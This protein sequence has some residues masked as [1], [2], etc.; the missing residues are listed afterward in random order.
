MAERGKERTDADGKHLHTT[1]GAKGR[2]AAS[3]VS[4]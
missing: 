4:R 1:R 3:C 2:A